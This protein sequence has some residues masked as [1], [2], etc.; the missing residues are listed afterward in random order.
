MKNRGSVQINALGKQCKLLLLTAVLSLYVHYMS[1]HLIF[2]DQT[3]VLVTNHSRRADSIMAS[4]QL[5][6]R[7]HFI[8]ESDTF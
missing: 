7:I 4:F 2:A 5:I 8:P 6:C 3:L 1:T